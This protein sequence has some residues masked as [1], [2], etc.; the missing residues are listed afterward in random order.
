MTLD[1]F[2]EVAQTELE[3]FKADTVHGVETDPKGAEGF[4]L[5]RDLD[6]WW[7]EFQ[8]WRNIVVLRRTVEALVEDSRMMIK[9]SM[10]GTEARLFGLVVKPKQPN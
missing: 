8:A 6:D 1:K 7:E 2:L 5:E 9:H 10:A 3:R 4:K